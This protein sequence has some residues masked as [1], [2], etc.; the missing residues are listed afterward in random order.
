MYVLVSANQKSCLFTKVKA[1]FIKIG[2]QYK[3]CI[4]LL[5]QSSISSFP[6]VSGRFLYPNLLIYHRFQRGF[7]DY[8]AVRGVYS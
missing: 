4:T 8:E 2:L 7:P 5:L 3:Q 1:R 6:P